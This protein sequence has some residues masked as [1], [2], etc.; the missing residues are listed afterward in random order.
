MIPKKP[1]LEP[2]AQSVTDIN[3]FKLKKQLNEILKQNPRAILNSEDHAIQQGNTE[4]EPHNPFPQVD[5]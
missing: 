2:G 3:K 5:G 1:Q 4:H